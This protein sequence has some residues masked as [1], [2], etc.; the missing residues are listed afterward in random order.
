MAD[1][2]PEQGNEKTE[3]ESQLQEAQQ[4]LE[5]WKAK[6]KEADDVKTRLI[7]DKVD[8]DDVKTKAQKEMTDLLQKRDEAQREF[9]ANMSR[10]EELVLTQQRRNQDLLEKRKTLQA[11]LEAAREESVRLRENFKVRVQVPDI[12][13][14]FTRQ[15]PE[16]HHQEGDFIRGVFVF[17]QMP[18][19]LL[20]GGQALITFEEEQ[21]ASQILRLASCT[22]PCENMTV[23]VE[24]QKIRMNPWVQF[25]VHLNVSTK[26]V[27]V[28]NIPASCSEGRLEDRLEI[29]LSRPSRG[30][31]EVDSL[32]YDR[33]TGTAHVTFLNPGVAEHL[34]IKGGYSVDLDTRVRVKIENI[35]RQELRQ[36]QTFCASTKRTVL[37]DNI[38]NRVD[39]EEL[40]DQLEI[41]FQKPGNCGGEIESLHYVPVGGAVRALFSN[42]TVK[43]EN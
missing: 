5:T 41:Y 22:V 23:D 28:S 26:E 35:H 7:F 9:A 13:V 18:S 21:V 10:Q 39:E 36:F 40:Q 12:N 37:L 29:S 3:E 42:D 6:V 34:A 14:K 32:V 30:G 15:A 16:D 25:E 8:V 20:R 1:V 24:P 43:T 31:G 27:K 17:R 2:N 19:V 33:E 38:K 4:E 11:K